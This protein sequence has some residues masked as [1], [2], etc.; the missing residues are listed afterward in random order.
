MLLVA[1][2]IAVL[3]LILILIILII[4]DVN[5]G[6]RAKEKLR[7]VMETRHQLLLAVSHDI[8][9]PLNTISGYLELGQTEA[10]QDLEASVPQAYAK[11]CKSHT[12]PVG[13]FITI[14][15]FGTRY[16]KTFLVHPQHQKP[17]I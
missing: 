14:F 11:C 6:K 1:G 5:K 9:T 13:K 4:F 7:Q 16:S 15:K 8:K 3:V 17:G 10:P 12:C 2:G